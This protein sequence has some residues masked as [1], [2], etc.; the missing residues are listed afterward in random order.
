MDNTFISKMAALYQNVPSVLLPSIRIAQAILES[1][2][3]QSELA[4]EANNFAGIK[5]SKEWTGSTHVKYSNEEHDGVVTSERSA[6][7]KYASVEEFV[8]DHS[9]FITSTEW[10]KNHYSSVIHA[11]GYKEQAQA[12]TGLYATDS[13]YGSKLIELIEKYNLTQ[14]DKEKE[15]ESMAKHLVICG[16]GKNPNGSYDPGAI[17]SNGTEAE[18]VRRLA[19]AM[20]RYNHTD[21]EYITEQNVYEHRNINTYS[22]YESITELHLNAFNGQAKGCEVLIWHEYNADDLDNALLA[23]LAKYF[24]NRGIKKRDNLYNMSVSA[25]CGYNYRLVECCFVDNS[26]DMAIFSKSLDDIARQFVEAITGKAVQQPTPQE[27]HQNTQPIVDFPQS[28]RALTEGQDVKVSK[29]ATH[30]QNGKPIN[31]LVLGN[32][33]TITGKMDVQQSHSK[34]A[35]RLAT[36]NSAIGW[37]LEQ[38]IVEAWQTLEQAPKE[39]TQFTLGEK[40]YKIEEV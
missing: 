22:G 31:P 33:Y 19:T 2:W 15:S 37:V 8:K 21:I 24:V 23:I 29:H 16:H 38:D 14:Y 36:N 27:E 6:F 32:T 10:R 26:E 13:G 20:S 35:Y 39:S 9:Q 17:G 28:F 5:A 25:R 30:Y 3:G 4:K 12:L 18:W 40:T 7:R 34:R 11:K 1:S